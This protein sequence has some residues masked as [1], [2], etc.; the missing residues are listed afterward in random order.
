MKLEDGKAID[1]SDDK[2]TKSANDTLESNTSTP[3]VQIPY[4]VSADSLALGT[5]PEF[6][7]G[8]F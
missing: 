6:Q 3:F 1:K 2:S 5:T 8:Y 4:Q 7:V